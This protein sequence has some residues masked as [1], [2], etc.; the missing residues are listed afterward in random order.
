MKTSSPAV[1]E[2]EAATR[3]RRSG[4]ALYGFEIGNECGPLH[5]RSPRRP[6]VDLTPSSRSGAPSRPR[7]A[8]ARPARRSPGPRPHRSL[9]RRGPCPSPRRRGREILL[10]TQHYYRANGQLA[11]STIDCSSDPTR[12]SPPSSRPSRPRR[13]RTRH[14]EGYRCSE[15]NSFYNGGAPGVSDAYGTALWAIDFLFTNAGYGSSGVNFHGGGDGTGYTPIAD[16]TRQGRRRAPRL[17]RDAPLRARRPGGGASRRPGHPRHQLQRVRR[18][19]PADGHQRRPLEQ[20]R[21]PPPC[22]PPWTWARPSLRRGHAARG[23][24]ARRHHGG[25]ARRRR[26]RRRRL[27]SRPVRPRRYRRRERRSRSTCRRRAPCSSARS[28]ADPRD[29]RKHAH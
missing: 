20:G 11:T 13:P 3:P 27:A 19:A 17:L 15:C 14:P 21:A 9:R 8:Q 2:D 18:R 28:D 12:P 6:P 7:S 25:H 26:G 10:L 16:A 22:M 23:P 29:P 24:V 1:A 4:S 5:D